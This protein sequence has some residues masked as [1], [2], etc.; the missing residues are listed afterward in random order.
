MPWQGFERSP[1]AASTPDLG[2]E[3]CRHHVPHGCSGRLGRPDVDD[4]R[5]V[6]AQGLLDRQAPHLEAVL[7]LVRDDVVKLPR[8]S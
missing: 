6:I 2:A 3:Q 4:D 5:G 8:L 1:R 7:R